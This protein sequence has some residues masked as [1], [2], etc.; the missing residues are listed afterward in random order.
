MHSIEEV[1]KACNGMLPLHVYERIFETAK[2]S[3]GTTFLEVGTAHAAGTVCLALGLQASGRAGKV[4]TFEKIL[5]GSRER[6]G[7]YDENIA[8]IRN[9]LA[10]F[11]VA[12]TVELWFYPI[13]C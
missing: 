11:G 5:G 9:N 12:D 3:S 13:V 4:Y 7:D 2:T 10:E 1:R 6:Y 8:I